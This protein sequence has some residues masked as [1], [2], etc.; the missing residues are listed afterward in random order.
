[1]SHLTQT[2]ATSAAPGD[3]PAEGMA[4]IPGGRFRMGSD[5]HYPEEAPAH[6]VTVGGFW[7]DRYAVTNAEFKRFVEATGHVTVA[8]WNH[9]RGPASNIR[10]LMNHPVVH[11][12]FEDA[13]AYAKWAGKELPT[14][15]EW[16]FASRGGLECAEFV[17]GD[18]L[19]PGGK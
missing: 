1:M 17:W 15:A 14:E 8:D 13:E 3:P 2:D 9:P 19:T 5:H 16:E 18:E 7:M 12:A 6:N 11:V 10:T 4:W